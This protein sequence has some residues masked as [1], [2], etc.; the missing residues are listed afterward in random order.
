MKNMEDYNYNFLLKN[1]DKYK[2]FAEELN[3]ILEM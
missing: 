3:S 2:E 1:K